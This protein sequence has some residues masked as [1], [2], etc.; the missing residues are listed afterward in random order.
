MSQ[1]ETYPHGVPC[2]VDLLVAEPERAMAFYGELFGW[3]YVGPGPMPDGGS[4]YVARLD[5]ADVAGIASVSQD[6]PGAPAAWNTYVAVDSA[7]EATARARSAG[8]NVIAG[9]FDAQPAGRGAVIEAPDGSI[10]CMWEAGERQGA[11]RVN[12]HSAWAMSILQTTSPDVAAR[13]YTDVFGW[14]LWSPG[15]GLPASL[16]RLPGYVGG[17][18]EQPVPRDVVAAMLPMTAP[19]APGVRAAWGIDFWIA[20]ADRAASAAPSLGGGVI[21]PP[22][23][24]TPF[25]RTV[26]ADPFGAT[27]SVSQLRVEALAD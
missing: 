11:Q 3:E 27:L 10:I 12:E 20:D 13:F 1:R 9:P 7:D 4:Y 25:R 17:E 23:E 18:P 21:A 8:G 15:G 24:A 2:W 26:L 5:G 14:E 19:L 16:F 22:H 6:N